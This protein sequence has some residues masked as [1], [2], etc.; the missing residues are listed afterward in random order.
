KSTSLVTKREAFALEVSFIIFD[1]DCRVIY[2]SGSGPEEG[3]NIFETTTMCSTCPAPISCGDGDIEFTRL[4]STSIDVAWSG[5]YDS[6]FFPVTF[7]L[8]YGPAGFMPN[9]GA[10]T[11]LVTSDTTARLQPLMDTTAYDVYI[12]TLCNAANDTST[13]LGPFSFFTPLTTDVGVSVITDPISDC[14]VGLQQIR[15]GL[16]NFGGAPQSFIPFDFSVNGMPSGVSMPADGL[17]TGV[18]GVDSTEFTNFD[19]FSDFTEPGEYEIK[20]WTALEGD[21]DSTNDTLT[22]QLVAIPNISTFPYLEGLEENDGFWTVAQNNFGE[23][24]WEWGEP[25]GPLITAAAVG[26][27]AWVTNLTG[28]Y[29]NSEESFLLSPCFDFTDLSEDAIM[30]FFLYVETENNFDELYVEYTVDRENWERLGEAGTGINWYNDDINQWWENDGG[31]GDQWVPA[32]QSLGFLAGEPFV[33]FRFVFSS[34]GSVTREGVGIDNIY[35]GPQL[36]RDLVAASLTSESLLPCGT[37]MDTLTFSFFNVG[38]DTAFSVELNY[39]VEGETIVTE[40]FMDTLAPGEQGV[41][42]FMTPYNGIPSPL[43]ILAWANW[44]NDEEVSNDTARITITN[45]LSLPLL[46]DF[47]S[48][49]PQNWLIDADLTIA[50]AHNSGSTVIFDNLWSVDPTMRFLTANYGPIAAEDS[51]LFDY[52]F[53]DFG[54]GLDPTILGEGDSLSITFI[55]DCDSIVS[56]VLTI[57][58]ENHEPTAEFTRVGIEIPEGFQGSGVSIFFEAFWGEGDYFLDIDNIN[59]KQ[60]APTFAAGVTVQDASTNGS[61]DGGIEVRPSEGLAPFTYEWDTG[62]L[63]NILD[64]I[65]AGEYMLTITDAQGCTESLNIIVEFITGTEEFSQDLGRVSA[66]PNP[67]RGLLNFTIE[68]TESRE[69][70]LE[71]INQVGQVIFNRAYGQQIELREQLDIADYPAGIYFLR[72]FAGDQ[73]RTLR[74][75]KTR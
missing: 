54:S 43:E 75:M 15:V 71:M 37:E 19:I 72:V 27:N 55:F 4:R 30:S 35:I 39:L 51:V 2:E 13:L 21:Q 20:V 74:I 58:S 57:N 56:N 18:L 24:S 7:L 28:N 67:T 9:S 47:E 10:G 33:R 49:T 53:V 36:T 17:Y 8:E 46:E 34:D 68:L 64:S 41:Y 16:T 63:T 11:F 3:D 60:C 42:T 31:F 29:N 65:P 50:E 14:E 6:I 44:E 66:Y 22:V 73:Y 12:S 62:D 45:Q 5:V 23:A 59:I 61:S 40:T 26:Q 38:T 32:V 48:G 69:V 1:D 70:Q 25:Q 52:R